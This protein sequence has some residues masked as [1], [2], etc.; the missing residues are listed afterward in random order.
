MWE[1]SDPVSPFLLNT[2]NY[3]SPLNGGNQSAHK[4]IF[5]ELLKLIG[6]SVTNAKM[7][8]VTIILLLSFHAN[9]TFML[10]GIPVNFNGEKGFLKGYF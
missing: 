10:S 2:N 6:T 5:L 3:L 9:N 8:S 7:A 4:N 1:P